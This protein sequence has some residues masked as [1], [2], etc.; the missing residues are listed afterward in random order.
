MKKIFFLTLQEISDIYH[1]LS[2]EDNEIFC[3][4][5]GGSKGGVPLWSRQNFASL[6]KLLSKSSSEIRTSF[7]SA[8]G[9]FA[10]ICHSK[11]AQIQSCDIYKL[12]SN[13]R[14][15][16]GRVQ[17]HS[18]KYNIFLSTR[19]PCD[20]RQVTSIETQHEHFRSHRTISHFDFIRCV[21]KR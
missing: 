14:L 4:P 11:R 8:V 2:H 12:V 16:F 7:M 18:G 17:L 21:R 15:R 10:K 13:R 9:F 20:V 3:T 1:I 6:P 5:N 19:L